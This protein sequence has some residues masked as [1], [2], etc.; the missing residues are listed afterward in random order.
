M[1]EFHCVTISI[2]IGEEE[3]TDAGK[4]VWCCGHRRWYKEF[5]EFTEDNVFRH[6]GGLITAKKCKD[7]K[8][9]AVIL[10][11]MVSQ[12]RETRRSLFGEGLYPRGRHNYE[13]C[14]HSVILRSGAKRAHVEDFIDHWCRLN[15]NV[16]QDLHRE[17]QH[18]PTRRINYF[19]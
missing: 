15:A 13:G 1:Q 9:Y 19:S 7:N 16:L 6:P 18:E 12:M 10:Q 3:A 4:R 17:I 14:I 2:G 11:Y 5:W 8:I